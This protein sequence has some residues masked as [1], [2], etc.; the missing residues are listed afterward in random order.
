MFA[1]PLSSYFALA[2]FAGLR[3]AING[4]EITRIAK[5]GHLDRIIDL[6]AGIIRITPELAKTKDVRQVVIQPF[7][8]A[9]LTRYPFYRYTFIPRNASNLLMEIR[10]KFAIGHDCLR[11]TFVSMHVAR[12]RS[13]GDTALQAGNSEAIIKKHYLNLVSPDEA[14][15]FW[16]ILPAH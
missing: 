6:M 14:D 1:P 8:Q 7:L 4:G 12:F 16:K 5:L 11:H 2:T 3:S 13:M 10:R 9:W 15:A